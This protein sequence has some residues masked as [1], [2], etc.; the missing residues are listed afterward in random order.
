MRFL[1]PWIW[2]F[3]FVVGLAFL[4]R[5]IHALFSEKAAQRIKNHPIVH[6]FWALPGIFSALILL[7][8]F[9]PMLINIWPPHWLE[10]KRQRET[11][12]QRVQAAGGWEKL[13]QDCITFANTNQ[14]EN[15]FW[16]RWNTNHIALPST[17]TGLNP[18]MINYCPTN[19]ASKSNQTSGNEPEV[20]VLHIQ[21]FGM[22]R[23]GGHDTP[24]YGLDILR[25]PEPKDFQPQ[26]TD[27]NQRYSHFHYRKIADGIYE[28]Y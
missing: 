6:G 5:V 3:V 21:I 25:E 4:A 20:S 8:F 19:L 18:F 26:S 24:Y 15:V 7:L 16:I 11:V 2:L 27:P 22:H 13:R 1:L 10:L 12:Q 9:D 14:N 17:L 23:T 28:V